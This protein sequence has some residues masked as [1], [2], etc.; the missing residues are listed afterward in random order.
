LQYVQ[1]ASW[2]GESGWK[3]FYDFFLDF[4]FYFFILP[5]GV[6]EKL[7]PGICTVQ[8][9]VF[10]W[11]GGGTPAYYLSLALPRQQYPTNLQQ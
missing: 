4:Y 7:V 8:F 9:P 3:L 11:Q 10:S 5:F 2:G 6:R 1:E